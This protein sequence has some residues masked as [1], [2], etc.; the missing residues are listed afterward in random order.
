MALIVLPEKKLSKIEYL[1]HVRSLALL[2]VSIL[3]QLLLSHYS[4]IF[5]SEYFR[6]KINNILFQYKK[7]PRGYGMSIFSNLNKWYFKTKFTDD[8]LNIENIVSI[9]GKD[10]RLEYLAWRISIGPIFINSSHKCL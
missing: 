8:G 1:T 9:E 4:A 10:N 2:L 3:L 7:E 5:C 6:T